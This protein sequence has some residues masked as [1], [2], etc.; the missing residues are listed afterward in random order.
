MAA[1]H[2]KNA[3]LYMSIAGTSPLI[4][5]GEVTEYSLDLNADTV[6]TTP[7]GSSNKTYVLGYKDI[8]GSFA[9]NWDEVSNTIWDAMKSV[10]GCK[11]ALYPSKLFPAKVFSGPAWVSA[12]LKLGSNA[13]VTID[14]TFVANGTWVTP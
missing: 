9:A 2:G 14:G 8:K 6:E 3:Q 5:V 11:V 12:S 10:D 7:L 1:H 4:L 13:A